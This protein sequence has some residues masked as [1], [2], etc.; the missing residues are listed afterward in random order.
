MLIEIAG[1]EMYFEA[2]SR[3]GQ[4]VDSG[5]IHRQPNR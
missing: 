5:T 4:A 3:A 2:L 1:D